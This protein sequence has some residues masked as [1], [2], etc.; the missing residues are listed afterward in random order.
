MKLAMI[1]QDTYL[2]YKKNRVSGYILEHL[3]KEKTIF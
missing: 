2:K 3:K 1:S